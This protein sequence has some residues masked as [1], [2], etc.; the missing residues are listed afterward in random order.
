VLFL[1]YVSAIVQGVVNPGGAFR[2]WVMVGGHTLLAALLVRRYSRL[3]PEKLSSI[4]AF[5]K[6]IWDLFYL[7]YVLYPF[8]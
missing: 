7:E 8:L 5:Y 2:Q 1:N 3:E 4:K 6:S